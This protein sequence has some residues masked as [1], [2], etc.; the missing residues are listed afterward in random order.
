MSGKRNP[1][2]GRSCTEF[3]SEEQIEQ[4]HDNHRGKNH[5]FYGKKRPDHSIRMSGQKNP[6]CGRSCTE[7]MSE[8]Q[9][10]EWKKNLSASNSGERNGFFGKHHTEETI[11]K[12]KSKAKERIAKNGG[13]GFNYGKKMPDAVKRHLSLVRKGVKKT[14]EQLLAFNKTRISKHF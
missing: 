14:K 7:F 12:I 5:Q 3:M 9:I 8:E 10:L 1:M 13:H 6:M 2:Y 11:N 4:W